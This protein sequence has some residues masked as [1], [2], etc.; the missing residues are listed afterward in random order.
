ML[1]FSKVRV[2]LFFS[3]R[4]FSLLQIQ[5]NDTM[6]GMATGIFCTGGAE[7]LTEALRLGRQADGLESDQTTF[8]HCGDLPFEQGHFSHSIDST[9]E[10]TLTAAHREA[11]RSSAAPT[12]SKFQA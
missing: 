1:S 8:P 10:G 6:Q 12:Q 3:P 9:A 5:K 11:N 2:Y 4:H 7:P